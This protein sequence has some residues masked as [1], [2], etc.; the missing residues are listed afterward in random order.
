MNESSVPLHENRII[1]GVLKTGVMVEPQVVKAALARDVAIIVSPERA[2][3]SDLWPCIWALAAVLERQ[4]TGT[5]SIDCGL[6]QAL[7]AP[8]PLGARCAF[9]TAPKTAR[10]I[11]IGAEAPNETDTLWGDVRGNCLGCDRLVASADPAHP[12]S[13]FALAGYLGFAALARAV[14]IPPYRESFRTDYLH[15][16]LAFAIPPGPL[17]LSVIGLGHLGQAYLA[18]LY[19]VFQNIAP[20]VVLID[21]DSF[22]PPNRATQILLEDP[23]CWNGVPK[24]EY[25]ERLV[26]QWGWH[27]RGRGTTLEWGWRRPTGDPTLTLL[28]LDDLDVRR[29]AIAAGYEWIIDAGLGASFLQPRISWHAL[30]P[31]SSLARSLFTARHQAQQRLDALE[32]TPLKQELSKT[33]G[34]CGWLTFQSITAAAPSMGLAGAAFAITELLN[35]LAGHRAPVSGR[36]CLWSTMLPTYREPLAV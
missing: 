25:L 8:T 24:H 18:L 5:V 1:N 28:G 31:D 19:F 2:N 22:E 26:Q 32:G 11:F 35:S 13:C 36:A 20:T 12:V 29:M 14:G 34:E 9:G 21:R 7:P 23:F 16:P 15:L 17:N 30:P 4:F 6:E 27:V 3:S 10:R 33:P